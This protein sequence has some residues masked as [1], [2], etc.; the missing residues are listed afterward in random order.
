L[1]VVSPTL[2]VT[3]VPTGCPLSAAAEQFQP[4][5]DADADV[6]IALAAVAATTQSTLRKTDLQCGTQTTIRNDAG[7]RIKR[8]AHPRSP[9]KRRTDARMR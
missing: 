4:A 5:A 1:H 7:R 2:A 8:F 6:T 3:G 9:M